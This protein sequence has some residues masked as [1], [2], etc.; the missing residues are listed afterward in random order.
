MVDL[1]VDLRVD[2]MADMMV[3]VMVDLR[4]DLM[5]GVMV[6]WMVSYWVGWKVVMKVVWMADM[7]EC[8]VVG[9]WV[10]TSVRIVVALWGLRM[11][12][13]KEQQTVV[14]KV[15]NSVE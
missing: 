3:D 1:K 8:I 9:G 2:L 13:K 6:D 15:D 4:V 12:D 11:V 7:S 5:A 14:E 10:G